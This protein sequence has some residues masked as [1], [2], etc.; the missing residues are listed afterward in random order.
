MYIFVFASFTNHYI[1]KIHLYICMK[2]DLVLFHCFIL[3]Y[4][5]GLQ[6]WKREILMIGAP[7]NSLEHTMYKN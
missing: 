6:W 4:E 5:P 3:L 7:R 2:K 1:W